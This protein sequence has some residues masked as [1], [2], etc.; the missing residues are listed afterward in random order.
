MPI[1]MSR[2]A[3]GSAKPASG[4]AALLVSWNCSAVDV[5]APTG[6]EV[7]RDARVNEESP[8]SVAAAEAPLLVAPAGVDSAAVAGASVVSDASVVGRLLLA[9]L[10]AAEVA[11]APESEV[12][13]AERVGKGPLLKLPSWPSGS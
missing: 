1:A 5:A 13:L 11:M 9:V 10:A 6:G 4:E 7:V 2:I 3:F 12:P 8:D